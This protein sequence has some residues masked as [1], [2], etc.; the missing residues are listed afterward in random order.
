MKIA[1]SGY[2]KMGKEIEK[3]ALLKNHVIVAKIDSVEDWKKLESEIVNT[4][5]IIDFS[6]PDKVVENIKR[7]F[8]LSIPVVVGTTSWDDDKEMIKELCS[9]KN[10]ALFVASNFSIGV[11][12]LYEINSLLARLMNNYPEY[13]IS[14]EETHHIHKKDRP[15]G[16]AILI[17]NQ[18]IDLL[19]DKNQWILDKTN[20]PSDLLIKS[21]RKGEVPGTHIINYSSDIDE[22]E[23]QHTAKNRKGFAQGTILAAEWMMGKTGFFEMKDMLGVEE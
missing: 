12:I 20:T 13:D 16:T 1:L 15:S 7:S 19:K 10:Q 5:V 21:L 8:E 23:I 14:I 18:I 6:Q 3:I 9:A 11:N 4:D 22:I 2:G 17:A